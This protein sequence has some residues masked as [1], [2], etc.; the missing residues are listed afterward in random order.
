L[1]ILEMGVSWTICLCWP[2]TKILSIP[3]S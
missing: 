3:S 2:W 1:V